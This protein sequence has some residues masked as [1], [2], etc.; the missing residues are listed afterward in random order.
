ME[1]QF[2][3]QFPEFLTK[4]ILKMKT[5]WS[6]RKS[7]EYSCK[8]APEI[9]KERLNGIFENVV[10]SQQFLDKKMTLKPSFLVEVVHIFKKVD[11]SSHQSI[12]KLENLRSRL[13]I[14]KNFRRKSG[15]IRGQIQMQ[16]YLL[17]F[18]YISCFAVVYCYFSLEGC[19]HIIA[20]SM[21]LFITGFFLIYFL[22]RTIKWKI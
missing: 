18:I 9:Y 5:G 13:I 11:Q 21:A 3:S 22:G 14:I 20:L 8:E 10:F 7:F 6:F 19:G 4:I 17:I 16:C 12:E 2:C 1:K 15:V